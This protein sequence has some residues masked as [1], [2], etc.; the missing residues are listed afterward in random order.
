M[1]IACSTAL[2]CLLLYLQT[3]ASGFVNWDDQDYVINNPYI[4]N[5][6]DSFAW[7]FTTT[8][9]GWWMPLT[10]ISFA[11]DY[12]FWGLN[13]QGY[14]LTNILLHSVN[15]GLVVLIADRLLRKRCT[16][17]ATMYPVALILAGLIW[18]IHP[19]RVESVAWVTERKD[20]LN[21]VFSLG[22][23]FF[24]LQYQQQR[25]EGTSQFRIS[26][27][28]S[29][30]LFAFSLMAKSVSVGLPL[31]LLVAD[32]YPLQRLRRKTLLPLVAEKLPYLL[33]SVGIVALTL[34]LA[35]Q[36]GSLVTGMSFGMRSTISGYAIWE[37]L[38]LMLFP[39]GIIP[40]YIIP[41]PIPVSW[42]IKAVAAAALGI[43]CLCAGWK[44]PVVTAVFLC[45]IIPLVPTL[46]FTQNGIQSHAVR[47]TYLP[48][49]IPSVAAAFLIA[50]GWDYLTRCRPLFRY[51]AGALVMLILS[52]YVVVSY[53]QIGV[54][55]NS[56]ELWS[57]VIKQQPFD[58]AYFF[59]GLYEVDTGNFKA[60][61]SDYTACLDIA[62][63]EKMPDLFNL[64]A[65]RGEALANDGLHEEAV[66]D[67]STAINLSPRPLY[68]QHRG[69]SLK[70]LG[71]FRE[72]DEDFRLGGE[73]RGPITWQTLK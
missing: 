29:I 3:L 68:F 27:I 22:A 69:M 9:L 53:R 61:V 62:I 37:Y 73:G 16:T 18:G 66:R 6:G 14:H 41:D 60:A 47:F 49:I 34:Y 50:T 36:D 2:V 19:L 39:Y 44:R 72:A 5:L 71:R 67:F 65:F 31:L 51:V 58:Q 48:S 21:G 13:P 25:T 10:W 1:T 26:Y 38:R 40:L 70:K 46:S 33:L 11:V 4:R 52:T 43:A 54:W 7:A 55:K 23:I 64:Y 15:T 28:L 20:V 30:V 8:N 57:S 32:W 59:R 56:G 12:H 63:R 45:F 42:H 35:R 24:Y 17:S